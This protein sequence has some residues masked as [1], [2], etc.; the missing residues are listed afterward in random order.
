[1]NKR[2]LLK[3]SNE[4]SIIVSILIITIL[5]TTFVYGLIVLANSNLTRSRGR[6]L[7][8]EA[9]YAAESGVDAA[10]GK[11]NDDSNYTGS[12]GEVLV[13]DHNTTSNSY[14]ATFNVT[15]STTA[16]NNERLVT[17]T[18]YLY[19]PRSATSPSFSRQ[20]EVTAQRNSTSS[21]SSILSRNLIEIASS[22]KDIQARDIYLNGYINMNKASN[23]LIAENITIAGK[24]TGVGNCSIGGIGTLTKPSSF[25][26][27]GQTKTNITTAYNNCIT[28][29]GNITNANFN[30]L[31]NQTS[32]VKV[33]STF[34]PWAQYMDSSYLD[35]AGGCNDWTTGGSTRDI[36]K[37][38][39]T[40]KTH[41]PDSG[42]NI[43]SSCGTQGDLDL[44]TA[45]YNI[46]D[47]AHVRANL[48]AASA[49]S[50]T[51]YNPDPGVAGIKFI[52]VEGTVNFDHVITAPGSGP[53][54][55]VVYGADPVAKAGA[56]PYG[57][58]F[59]LG[60]G[61]T[62]APMLYVVASN[63][64]CIDK[65]K[66]SAEP[67]MGG[68]SG[69][70][71]YLATNSGTPHDLHLDTGFPVSAIPINLAWRAIRYRRI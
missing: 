41:Y 68:F 50:P 66:F 18:G 53:I 54:V 37:T 5:L 38:G 48:C 19:T 34:I 16:V 12:G 3:S 51:F 62:N 14:K 8:L 15:V 65:S 63:G 60:D 26:T 44:G 43:S 13:L 56:C 24:N 70:N 20:I 32:V 35:S 7:L 49:C 10:I 30:V 69:K 58:A 11:L 27:P 28:P 45:Q 42:S 31:A 40:K 46:T 36:P 55:M 17:A 23:N 1:M 61:Q 29:P 6:V 22:V 57:G 59:Y 2:R 64:A 9:Q 47:H 52:F 4:G 33:N 71:L 25:S 39:H 67:A 21:T